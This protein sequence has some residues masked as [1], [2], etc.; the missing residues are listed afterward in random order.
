MNGHEINTEV[1]FE[2]H[3]GQL[4]DRELAEFN[5]R[6]VF[7][8]RLQIPE[9]KKRTKRLEDQNKRVFGA[10]GTL[11]GIIGAAI[12]AALNKFFNV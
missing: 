2:L 11:S 5:A 6:Q 12:A 10:V 7:D 9:M 3:I 1:E 8:I 4:S